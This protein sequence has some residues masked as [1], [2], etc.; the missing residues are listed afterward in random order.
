MRYGNYRT[1][2]QCAGSEYAFRF[3]FD[4]FEDEFPAVHNQRFYGFKKM[5]FSNAFKDNSLI[6]DKV[7]ADMFRAFGVPS[8]WDLR[9]RICRHR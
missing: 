2:A 7:A 9:S 6:R 1:L 3:N 5:T 4:K 8:P